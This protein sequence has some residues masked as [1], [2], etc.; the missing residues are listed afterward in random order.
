MN[1]SDLQLQTSLLRAVEQ[2]GYQTALAYPAKGNSAGIG[3]TRFAGV[4]ADGN[5]QNS[6]VCTAYFAAFICL[7]GEGKAH[8]RPYFNP[9]AG[10]G[11]AN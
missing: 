2:A 5:R 1:F 6:C 8:P 9:Y 7:S 4:C 11:A 3:K 10:A